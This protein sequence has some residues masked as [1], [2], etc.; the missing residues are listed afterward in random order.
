MVAFQGLSLSPTEHVL[1][2]DGRTLYAGCSADTPF[3]P[4]LLGR[5][6]RVRSTDPITGRAVSLSVEDGGVRDLEPSTAVQSMAVPDAD[7]VGIGADA[8]P[9]VCGPINFFA[10]EEAGRAFTERVQ[11]TFLLTIEQGHEL[12]RRI[13]RALYGSALGDDVADS[14]ARLPV[15]PPSTGAG[16]SA[17]DVVSQ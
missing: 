5:A 14:R 12:G 16:T 7:G 2:V 10:T 1:E 9:A 6:A 4:E 13:N 3:L 8:I 15:T 11:G 17:P